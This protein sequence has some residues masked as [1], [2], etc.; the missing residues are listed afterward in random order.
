MSKYIYNYEDIFTDDPNDAGN[1]TMVIPDPI[2]EELGL[3]DGD[4]LDIEI[5]DGQLILRKNG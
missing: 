5:H 3:K 1:V 2:I 4:L